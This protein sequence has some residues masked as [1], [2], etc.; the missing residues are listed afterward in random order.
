MEWNRTDYGRRLIPNIID[1][2]VRMHPQR[3]AFMT[4]WSDSLENDWRAVTWK[5]YAN[6]INRCAHEIDGACGKAPKG[7]FPTLAYIGPQDVRYIVFMVA[8]VKAGY[9]VGHDHHKR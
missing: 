3:E 2:N 8:A 5:Q 9:V 7:R 1:E 4:Q 6:A